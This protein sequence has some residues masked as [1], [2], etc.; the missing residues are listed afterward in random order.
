MERTHHK[1]D[2]LKIIVCDYYNVAPELISSTSRKQPIPY[3]K[4]VISYMAQ[5]HFSETQQS[6]ARYFG[7]KNHSVVSL[8]IKNHI[9]QMDFSPKLNTEMVDL[10]RVIISKGLSKLSGKNNEWYMFLDLNNFFIATKDKKSILFNS[11]TLA[12]IETMLGDG[13]E[14]VEHKKTEKFLYKRL[15]Q[16]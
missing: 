6:L 5:K 13:W 10:N 9:D 3:I 4:K 12:E 11:H 14:I 15:K 16:N 2:L 1:I 7:Y 8:S